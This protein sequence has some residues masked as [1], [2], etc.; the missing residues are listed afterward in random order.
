MIDSCPSMTQLP[1]V[2]VVYALPADHSKGAI[3]SKTKHAMKHKT[4]PARLA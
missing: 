2:S 4:S 3:T 1:K